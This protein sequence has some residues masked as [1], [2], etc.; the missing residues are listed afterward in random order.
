MAADIYESSERDAV[1][2]K[3]KKDGANALRETRG[4]SSGSNGILAA[5]DLNE[6]PRPEI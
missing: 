6:L 2:S 3:L 1:A 5:G 4:K